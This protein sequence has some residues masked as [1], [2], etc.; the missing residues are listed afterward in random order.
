MGN[1]ERLKA[2]EKR[3]NATTYGKWICENENYIVGSMD[4]EPVVTTEKGVYICQTVYDH[5][6]CTENHKIYADAVFI[7]IA[8]ARQDIEFLLRIID[9]FMNK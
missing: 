7:A 6:S 5:Q 4:D 8:N 2:I 9:G 1:L 3:L